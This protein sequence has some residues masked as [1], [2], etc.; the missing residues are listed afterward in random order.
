MSASGG[1][2]LASRAC[3]A[4]LPSENRVWPRLHHNFCGV[5]VFACN[6]AVIAL[7][8]EF[9]APLH[10]A[11]SGYLAGRTPGLGGAAA[12]EFSPSSI[13]LHSSAKTPSATQGLLT[14]SALV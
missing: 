1:L 11:L 2:V 4:A 12:L 7:A 5:G 9:I 10:L 14:T 8:K 6:P 13:V 3:H